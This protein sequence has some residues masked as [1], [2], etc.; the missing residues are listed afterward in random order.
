[1]IATSAL[2]ARARDPAE[3]LRPLVRER[4]ERGDRQRRSTPHDAA[5][6]LHRRAIWPIATDQIVAQR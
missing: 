2:T 1:M 4:R 6:L 5:D 3:R